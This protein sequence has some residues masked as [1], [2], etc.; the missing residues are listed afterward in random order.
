MGRDRSIKLQH[1]WINPDS[2]IPLN[3]AFSEA[4]IVPEVLTV[5]EKLMPYTG[6]SPYLRY[7]P[8]KDPP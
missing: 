3:N 4:M 5:G 1:Y 7:V 2:V 8:N 6:E